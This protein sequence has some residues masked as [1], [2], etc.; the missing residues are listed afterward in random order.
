VPLP[1]VSGPRS[2]REANDITNRLLDVDSSYDYYD[3]ATTFDGED[4][5]LLDALMV[6]QCADPELRYISESRKEQTLTLLPE[7]KLI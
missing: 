7:G 4:T 5:R 6:L 3:N 1:Y 2:I